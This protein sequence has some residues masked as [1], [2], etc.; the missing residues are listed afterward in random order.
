MKYAPVIIP[1]LNRCDHLKRCLDSLN[2]NT[3]ATETEVYISVDFPPAERYQAGYEKVVSFLK[4]VEYR[5]KGFYVFFQEENLGP[6]QN[7]E[8][9]K[10]LVHEKSEVYISTE[11]DNEFSP[12]FLQYINQGL[13]IF[14]NNEHILAICGYKDTEWDYKGNEFTTSKLFPAY[15]YGAWFSKDELMY[16]EGTKLL[17]SKEN[18]RFGNMFKLFMRNKCF[19]YQYI[20]QVICSDKGLFWNGGEFRWCDSAKSMYMHF[21]EKSVIVPYVAKSR[22]WG[23]DGSG[24]NMKDIMSDGTYK[25]PEIDSRKEFDFIIS[26]TPKYNKANY[27]LGDKYLR[28]YA[29]VKGLCLAWFEYML[30]WLCGY[31]NHKVIQIVNRL[32][33]RT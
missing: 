26:D 23:N 15:G 18:L 10:S 17:F 2:E 11:D 29:T 24:V 1:T 20:T 30:L 4:Q 31:D 7:V 22:T 12:N 33:G 19:F 5:F 3:G 32:R 8:F 16:Q 21:S 14:E 28:R 27:K 6:K 25:M 13:E 9:L